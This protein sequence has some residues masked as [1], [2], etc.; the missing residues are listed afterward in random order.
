MNRWPSGKMVNRFRPMTDVKSSRAANSGR[1]TDG[2]NSS[3]PSHIDG[4]Q[5]LVRRSINQLLTVRAPERIG[6][7]RIRH[8]HFVCQLR[9]R[10]K[11]NLTGP[12]LIRTIGNKAA[13][14]GKGQVQFLGSR[15]HNRNRLAVAKGG[16]YHKSCLFVGLPDWYAM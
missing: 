4:H 16:Q 10:L 11:I 9:E 3:P 6:A 2:C 13:V 1:G 15:R 12:R 7:A 14:R 5:A 8:L